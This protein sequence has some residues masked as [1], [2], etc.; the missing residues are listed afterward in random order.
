[1]RSAVS[2]TPKVQHQESPPWPAPGH[3]YYV[4]G[5]LTFAYLVAYID[6]QIL[7]LLIEPIRHDLNISDTQVSLLGGFAFALFYTIMGVPIAWLADQRSRRAII[8]VGVAIWSVMTAFCGLAQN[9]V[10]LF[11]ARVGV[12]IGEASLTPSAYS[13]L[14]DYFPPRRLGRAM[15]VYM[16]GGAFGAG[17]ALVVGGAVIALVAELQQIALPVVG[18][19]Q[20]W[21]FAFICAALPGI[22]VVLLMTTVKE[23]FRRGRRSLQGEE[24]GKKDTVSPRAAFSF[25]AERWRIYVPLLAGFATLALAK[26]A[27]LMWTPTLFIRTYGWSASSIGYAFGVVLFIFGPLG[28]VGGG[29]I[30]DKLRERGYADAPVRVIVVT[31]FLTAPVTALMPL[32][33]TAAASLVLLAILTSLLFTFGAVVP[34]AFQLV[35][36]NRLRAQVAAFSIFIV[37]ILGM[38]LGPM[39]VALITDYGFGDDMALRYS[40]SIVGAVF[41]PLAALIFWSGLKSYRIEMLAVEKENGIDNH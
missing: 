21:Q 18:V 24:Q 17:L 6:R 22:L 4:L 5:V 30:A 12:G 38:G 34:A 16:A 14:A 23:P 32:M 2:T 9:F 36:P 31:G 10:Q 15:G 33:P 1:M 27:V 29:W 35:T 25:V 13:L 41:A 20:P 3:A 26:N 19:V 39:V 37:N 7:T 40:M 8:A 28:A 11:L